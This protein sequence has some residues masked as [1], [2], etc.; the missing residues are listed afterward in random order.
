MTVLHVGLVVFIIIA[1]L[2]KA[3]GSNFS[4]FSPYDA[5]G[6]FNG[7]SLVFFSYI[8]FDA[9]VNTAEEARSGLGVNESDRWVGWQA[10]RPQ[11]VHAWM[12][13]SHH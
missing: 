8:G 4:P 7:A 6:I 12:P 10:L 13:E 5:R 9:I 3:D 1:G 11:L 2:T